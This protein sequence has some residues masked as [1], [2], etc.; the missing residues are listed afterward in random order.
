MFVLFNANNYH[1]SIN[2]SDDIIE[3]FV[4]SKLFR[5]LPRVTAAVKIFKSNEVYAKFKFL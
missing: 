4:G 5:I 2:H 3:L 1:T